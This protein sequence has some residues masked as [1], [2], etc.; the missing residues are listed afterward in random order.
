MDA[1]DYTAHM[2]VHLIDNND[3]V[4][5]KFLYQRAPEPVRKRSQSFMKLFSAVKALS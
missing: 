4:N 5:V 3:I 1:V 2:L